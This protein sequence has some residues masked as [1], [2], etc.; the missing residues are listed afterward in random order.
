VI[1]E[2]SEIHGALFHAGLSTV[3]GVAAKPT[4]AGGGC[5]MAADDGDEQ[6]VA[7]AA[8]LVASAT[9]V[10]KSRVRPGTRRHGVRARRCCGVADVGG[11]FVDREL[12]GCRI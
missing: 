2:A 7:A 9:V 10:V 11:V 5:L 8:M 4:M 3:G 12:L 6:I 1:L